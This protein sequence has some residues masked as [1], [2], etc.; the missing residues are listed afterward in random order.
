MLSRGESCGNDDVHWSRRMIAPIWRFNNSPPYVTGNMATT[1]SVSTGVKKRPDS[2]FKIPWFYSIMHFFACLTFVHLIFSTSR[3]CVCK[4][5]EIL[6]NW[7][8]LS[9]SDDLPQNNRKMNHL[10]LPTPCLAWVY[11]EQYSFTKKKNIQVIFSF[12]FNICNIHS[13]TRIFVLY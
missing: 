3:V 2:P 1:H 10:W 4:Y 11:C 8:T 9:L 6:K 5:F 12:L 7:H 13:K